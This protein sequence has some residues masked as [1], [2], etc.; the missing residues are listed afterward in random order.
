MQGGPRHRFSGRGKRGARGRP[1]PIK[2][3]DGPPPWGPPQGFT[4]YSFPGREVGGGNWGGET[5]FPPR[6][7]VRALIP[8][9]RP[10][11]PPLKGTKGGG[12]PGGGG[13]VLEL[14]GSPL[15]SGPGLSLPG[16]RIFFFPLFL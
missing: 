16:G 6:K 2:V 14:R 7:P 3:E 9:R 4:P 1:P 5:N 12:S 8:A 15:A 13:P 10:I 11:Y